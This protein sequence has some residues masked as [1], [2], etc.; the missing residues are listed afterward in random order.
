MLK[1]QLL[2]LGILAAPVVFFAWHRPVY[3]STLP[4]ALVG[5][6]WSA[7]PVSYPRWVTHGLARAVPLALVESLALWWFTR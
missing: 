3:F 7:S 5:A 4:I 1:R 6:W 2:F